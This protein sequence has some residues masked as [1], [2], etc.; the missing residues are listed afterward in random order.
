M[1]NVPGGVVNILYNYNIIHKIFSASSA[2]FSSCLL[3]TFMSFA[4]SIKRKYLHLSGQRL[5]FLNFNPFAIFSSFLQGETN[6]WNQSRLRRACVHCNMPMPIV[7]PTLRCFW[8]VIQFMS[9]KKRNRRCSVC[10]ETYF[11]LLDQ[12]LEHGFHMKALSS[13][14]LVIK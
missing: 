2:F 5:F 4:F 11:V 14:S 9:P 12:I 1:K 13:L 10:T 3:F 6:C 7:F 8:S